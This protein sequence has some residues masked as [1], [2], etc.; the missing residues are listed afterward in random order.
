MAEISTILAEF[1]LR[2]LNRQPARV[3]AACDRMG[4]VRIRSRKGRL[5][6]IRSECVAPEPPAGMPDFAVRRMAMGLLKMTRRQ[7]NQ[8][9]QLIAGD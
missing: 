4:V 7:D 2:D 5:Y 1:T 3:M 6:E 8:L 9:D